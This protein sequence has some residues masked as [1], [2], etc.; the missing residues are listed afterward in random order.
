[1]ARGDEGSTTPADQAAGATTEAGAA[2]AAVTRSTG[3]RAGSATQG[4]DWGNP[5]DE[6]APPFSVYRDPAAAADKEAAKIEKE[7]EKL[8]SSGKGTTVVF[9]GPKDPNDGTQGVVV[10]GYGAVMKGEEV[11]LPKDEILRL[12][13]LGFKF[14][15]P[16]G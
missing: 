10:A 15:K 2:P 13:A 8:R 9:D 14:K 5:Y 4:S 7:R 1:M 16:N 3:S 12:E 11:T 6:T